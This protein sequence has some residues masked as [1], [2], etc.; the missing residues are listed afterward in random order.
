M[1]LTS[2]AFKKEFVIGN[3]KGK[4]QILKK[5]RHEFYHFFKTFSF[6]DE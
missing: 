3:L 2:K 1:D 4:I 5:I 6:R